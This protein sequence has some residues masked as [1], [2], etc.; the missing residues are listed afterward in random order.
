MGLRIKWI[1]AE[2]GKVEPHSTKLLTYWPSS[3]HD[4]FSVARG[5][6]WAICTPKPEIYLFKEYNYEF[7][8]SK[9]SK[10]CL[11]IKKS[12]GNH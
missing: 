10:I 1:W 9:Y 11:K 2:Y 7:L 3:C 5:L 8:K 12:I 6:Q 4:G